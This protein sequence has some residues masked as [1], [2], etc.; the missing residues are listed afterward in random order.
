M[1]TVRSK[2]KVGTIIVQTF[3]AEG[4]ILNPLEWA[5]LENKPFTVA[6]IRSH[7]GSWNRM[8]KRVKTLE[9]ELWAIIG[10]EEGKAYK[11]VVKVN[12]TQINTDKVNALA[13]L[14]IK[15]KNVK[16]GQDSKPKSKE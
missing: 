13:A 4:K 14:V 8:L 5:D 15:A 7:L 6:T 16:V 9:P 11:P 1:A 10:T 12:S 2:K 3:I